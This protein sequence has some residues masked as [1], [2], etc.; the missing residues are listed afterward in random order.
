M[1]ATVVCYVK[2]ALKGALTVNQPSKELLRFALNFSG[3]ALTLLKLV[4]QGDDELTGDL[5]VSGLLI[6]WKA[7]YELIE[8]YRRYNSYKFNAKE[9]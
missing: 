4:A 7:K 8:N 1:I 9:A 5:G 2:M 6:K 3:I